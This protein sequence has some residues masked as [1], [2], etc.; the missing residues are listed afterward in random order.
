MSKE[1]IMLA[2]IKSAFIFANE[3]G[4]PYET[5]FAFVTND[6]SKFDGKNGR[7]FAEIG[8]IIKNAFM[9]ESLGYKQVSKFI[10]S[11]NIDII[12]MVEEE[13]MK[14]EKKTMKEDEEEIIDVDSTIVEESTVEEPDVEETE[15]GSEEP[16]AE[17]D[18]EYEEQQPT[19]E[20]NEL[21]KKINALCEKIAQEKSPLKRH[22]NQFL[23]KQLQAKIER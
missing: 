4:V 18:L 12:K 7:R 3:Q 15:V 22:F 8:R 20:G 16:T 9:N 6:F 23:V 2:K 21:E 5:T 13:K 11:Q 14:G 17:D 1:E 10:K 19:K